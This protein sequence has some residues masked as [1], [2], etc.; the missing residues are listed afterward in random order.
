MDRN[1]YKREQ[2]EKEQK[3]KIEKSPYKTLSDLYIMH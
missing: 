2:E 1:A 3:L